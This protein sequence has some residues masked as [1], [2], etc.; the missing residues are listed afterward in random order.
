MYIERD[1]FQIDDQAFVPDMLV[2]DLDG[3]LTHVSRATA[4]LASVSDRWDLS[5]SQA[6][7]WTYKR[8]AQACRAVGVSDTKMD[9]IKN[10]I[11][12]TLTSEQEDTF[13]VLCAAANSNIPCA[14][15]SNGPQK[16]GKLVLKSLKL[17]EFFQKAV[18]REQMAYIKP[19]PRS[20]EVVMQFKLSAPD[21][22]PNV[23]VYGDRATDVAL[24]VNANRVM[25][26]HFIPVAVK[27]TNAAD[28]IEK[29]NREK[30]CEGIIFSSQFTM[31]C[32]LSPKMDK[33]FQK[34]VDE[35]AKEPI[36]VKEP[37]INR[38]ILPAAIDSPRLP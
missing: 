21:R 4:K 13:F 32:S 7:A 38:A 3:T 18:F 16:W 26:Y 20:L 34:Y 10:G 33:D 30:I 15:V 1:N 5:I 24:A 28:A 17:D 22:V 29:M 31:A 8:A 11:V 27:G 36:I 19:D 2:S 35:R 14:I 37:H 23:W 6:L 9:R 25:P 12:N